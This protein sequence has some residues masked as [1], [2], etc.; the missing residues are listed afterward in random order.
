MEKFNIGDMVRYQES[1]NDQL[2]DTHLEY[3]IK[4]DGQVV[5]NGKAFGNGYSYEVLYRSHNRLWN[6]NGKLLKLV[7]PIS[8]IID[9]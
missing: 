4:E 6:I 5:S 8:Y 3:I 7:E 9:L 1:L 2:R